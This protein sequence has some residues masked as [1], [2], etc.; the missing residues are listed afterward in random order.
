MQELNKEQKEAVE[1]TE[2]ALLVLSGAGTG[3]TKVITTRL[4]YIIQNGFA[5]PWECVAVTFTN[6]AASEMKERL[7]GV[8]GTVQAGDVWLGTFHSVGLKLL[9]RFANNIGYESNFTVLGEDDQKKVVKQLLEA[10][11]IDVKKVT[12]DA[13]LNIIQGWKDRGFMPGEVLDVKSDFTGG[14]ILRLYQAYQNRL[15]SMNA[16]D[17][18]DLLLLCLNLFKSCPD[19]LQKYQNQFK[20]IMVDEYQDTNAVQYMWLRML[21]KGHNNLCCVGDD[22]QSIYSWRGAEIN[23]ILSFDKDFKD[24][25]VIRLVQNYRS[26]SHILAAASA[27]IGHNRGRLGKELIVAEGR[28][29]DAKKIKVC[30]LWDWRQEADKAVNIIEDAHRHGEPYKNMAVLVRTGVQTREFEEAFI[31]NAIP[32][33]VIGGR[34]F[35]EREEIRD[36]VAYLRLCVITSDDMALERIINKPRRGIGDTTIAVIRS[37]AMK[38]GISMFEAAGRLVEDGCEELKKAAKSSVAAFI[39]NVFKWQDILKDNPTELALERILED[40]GYIDMWK[41]SKQPEAEGKLDNIAE[42]FGV[43]KEGFDTAAEFLEHV[44]L[45]ADTDDLSPLDKVNVMTLHSAKGLEFDT[46]ILPG[47]EEGLFPHQR[48]LDESGEKGLEEERRLAYVGLTRA[49]HN[50]WI[51]FAG[52]RRIYNEWQNNPPS[53]FL[54]EIPAEDVDGDLPG[55]KKEPDFSDMKIMWGGFNEK[56]KVSLKPKSTLVSKT[57]FYKGQQ[58]RHSLFGAG[59]VAKV[60]GDKLEVLFENVGR[61]NILASFVQAV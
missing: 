14:S 10:E 50:L 38:E 41:T 59:I 9:R 30:G 31:S 17:F 33:Q 27:L 7:A 34:K 47:W 56:P 24:A 29:D 22:D 5:R 32:Y 54:T 26:G 46:V 44:A 6:K 20:Y 15:H 45:V 36:A 23:N 55:A 49:K 43:I 2:G 1:T 8:I 13:A 19:I 58:V 51:I 3:K 18:G 28:E 4:A 42:L 48:S 11:G 25:K 12:P 21:A 37:V 60:E 57:G 35:Y 61:K 53:R 39:S 40:S 52:S 16:M